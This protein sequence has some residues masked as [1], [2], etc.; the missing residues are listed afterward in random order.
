MN[1]IALLA[2]GLL[3]SNCALQAQE[4][5]APDGG[6]T[7]HV[8]GVVLLPVPG[9]PFS[10][11]TETVWTRPLAGGG[12]LTT[13]LNARL[14]RDAEGRMYRE[15]RSFV[16]EGSERK[17]TL[18]EIEIFDPVNHIKTFCT[19]AAQR[20]IVTDYLDHPDHRS[21][22]APVLATPVVTRSFTR[23]PL[24]TET[25]EGLTVTGTREATRQPSQGADA[26]PLVSTREFWYSAELETNL[27]VTRINP[28]EGTQ[29]IHLSN[30]HLGDPEASL[31]TV[32]KG[33]TLEDQRSSVAL[34]VR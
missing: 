21:P 33:F 30:I 19:M 5:R 17:S 28:V 10:A 8:T 18:H 26:A 22:T 25:I 14:A 15:R 9:K 12:S 34:K 32:P 11:D 4:V 2:L 3:F 20:C 23:E 31:F 1:R 24:G 27:A 13:H 29:A 16:P 7:Y 6:T